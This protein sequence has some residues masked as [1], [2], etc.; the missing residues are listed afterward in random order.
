MPFVGLS[1]LRWEASLRWEDGQSEA[2]TFIVVA[3]YPPTGRGA[4]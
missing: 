1:S 3:T 2:D 4:S